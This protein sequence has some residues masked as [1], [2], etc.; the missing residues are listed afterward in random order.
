MPRKLYSEIISK[1]VPGADQERGDSV[2]SFQLPGHLTV[3]GSSKTTHRTVNIHAAFVSDLWVWAIVDF[4]RFL[5]LHVISRDQFWEATDFQM[6]SA[7]SS[8]ILIF[9]FKISD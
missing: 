9:V 8:C 3:P 2:R 6:I 1:D 5:L 7:V 4:T